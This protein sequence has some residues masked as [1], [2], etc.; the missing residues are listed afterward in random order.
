MKLLAKKGI[1]QKIIIAILIVMSC[2]FIMPTVSS[3]FDVGGLLLEPVTD[4]VTT[5]GD[6]ILSAL[7]NF[8][9]NGEWDVGRWYIEFVIGS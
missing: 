1:V 6:T 7:Q 8:L 3:A 4:L 9:Y 5:I 2:N